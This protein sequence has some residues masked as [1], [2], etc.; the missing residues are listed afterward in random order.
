MC[1][2][3]NGYCPKSDECCTMITCG[4]CTS[5]KGCISFI[6]SKCGE[7]TMLVLNLIAI[8]AQIVCIVFRF[9]YILIGTEVAKAFFY[10]LSAY[11]VIFEV[12]FVMSIFKIKKIRHFFVF[13]NG[14]MGKGLFIIFNALLILEVK[15]TL[16]ICLGTLMIIIAVIDIRVGFALCCREK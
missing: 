12:L 14:Y 3:C 13:L 6:E 10:I 1:L 4:C 11:L 5:S 16:E 9:V 2:W 8:A 7:T 15:N